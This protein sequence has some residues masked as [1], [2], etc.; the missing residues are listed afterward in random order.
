MSN[1]QEPPH[2]VLE[3]SP[4]T[5]AGGLPPASRRVLQLPG[6]T[7]CWGVFS[8][9]EAPCHTILVLPYRSN[10]LRWAHW[11]L[12]CV[13]AKRRAGPKGGMRCLFETCSERRPLPYK[14]G[15]EH[16]GLPGS[17]EGTC[18]HTQRA[19]HMCLF[20]ASPSVVLACLKLAKEKVF[21]SENA[22]NQGLCHREPV[23]PLHGCPMP[24]AVLGSLACP[25]LQ[26]CCLPSVQSHPGPVLSA[27]GCGSPSSDTVLSVILS[28][29]HPR[30]LRAKP[31]LHNLSP[32]APAGSVT[33][34]MAG[35]GLPQLLCLTIL[36]QV[37]V[38]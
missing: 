28:S 22:T 29:G 32:A 2:N 31:W 3:S 4:G 6:S 25:P 23:P 17:W 10:I 16:R 1:F 26:S 38:S 12:T 18:L 20:P 9:P 37:T 8:R 5:L 11:D 14:A 33:G 7:S 36:V 13:V 34:C 27:S 24:G 35:Q 15:C 19:N 21:T 30:A